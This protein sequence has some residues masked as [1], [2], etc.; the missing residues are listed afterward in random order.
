ME[1]KI[2]FRCGDGHEWLTSPANLVYK[3]VSDNEEA[4]FFF[5]FFVLSSKES[6]ALLSWTK[7]TVYFF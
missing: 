2:A 3:N 5:F 1:E 7:S 4:R 6:L